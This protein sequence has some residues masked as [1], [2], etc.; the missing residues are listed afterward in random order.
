[1]SG[2]VCCGEMT[3]LSAGTVCQ[4]GPC[5]ATLIGVIQPCATSAECTFAP[6][7]VCSAPTGTEALIAMG[8]ISMICN[9]PGDG[10]TTTAEGGTKEGGTDGGSSSGGDSGSDSAAATDAPTGG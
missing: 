1:M 7:T 2:Q 6:D 9:P 10:G 8:G 4:A 5:T 3:G